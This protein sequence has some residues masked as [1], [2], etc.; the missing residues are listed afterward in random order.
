[1]KYIKDNKELLIKYL[2]V[3]IS[4]VIS[5]LVIVNIWL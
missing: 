1:M 3:L 5:T 4:N 2:L